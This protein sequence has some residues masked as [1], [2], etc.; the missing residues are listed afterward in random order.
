MCCVVVDTFLVSFRVVAMHVCA[1]G[2]CLSVCVCVC[3]CVYLCTCAYV[4]FKADLVYI[5]AICVCLV[6]LYVPDWH[7]MNFNLKYLC[8]ILS[9]SVVTE[10]K[11][12][13]LSPLE[14]V[15]GRNLVVIHTI[16]TSGNIL[17]HP[18]P[19]QVTTYNK[20]H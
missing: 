3:F 10:S 19:M 5:L 6:C 20:L 11:N 12:H 16:P 7:P 9:L 14:C 13:R 8:V 18:L 2:M 4:C 15:N 17:M 1:V